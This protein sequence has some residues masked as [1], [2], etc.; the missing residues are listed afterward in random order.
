MRWALSVI[1]VLIVSGCSSFS[2][3]DPNADHSN[4]SLTGSEGGGGVQAP[5]WSTDTSKNTIT[6]QNPTQ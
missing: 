4:S 6:N 2:S 5:I 3:Y 1:A